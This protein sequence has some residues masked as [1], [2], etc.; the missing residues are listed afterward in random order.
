MINDKYPH[1]EILQTLLGE[2]TG[3]GSGVTAQPKLSAVAAT[4][5]KA[6]RAGQLPSAF[7]QITLPGTA[8]EI[9]SNPDPAVISN[10]VTHLPPSGAN[11]HP[12]PKSSSAAGPQTGPSKQ[13]GQPG[14]QPSRSVEIFQRQLKKLTSVGVFFGEKQKLRSTSSIPL[15]STT[16]N[17]ASPNIPRRKISASA[18]EGQYQISVSDS[19][20]SPIPTPSNERLGKSFP[21]P[22]NSS[23]ANIP[24]RKISSP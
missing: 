16:S 3:T 10:N 17:S 12:S 5:L 20:H 14:Q 19:T 13:Q 6:K 7:G 21:S 8:E 24:R 22:C 2:N 4:L 9:S 11:G 23:S 18:L 1:L 15:I